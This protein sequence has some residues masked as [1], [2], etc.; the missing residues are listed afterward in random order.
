TSAT[1]ATEP[2]QLSVNLAMA[3]SCMQL[4]RIW[5]LL[6]VTYIVQANTLA[7]SIA[8]TRSWYRITAHMV[9]EWRLRFVIAVRAM[10]L[11]DVMIGLAAMAATGALM[12]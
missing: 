6:T 2:V 11:V 4:G 12:T 8:V 1:A 3:P 10:G 9:T 7:L 5:I